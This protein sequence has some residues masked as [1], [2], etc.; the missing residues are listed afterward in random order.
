MSDCEHLIENALNCITNAENS[1]KNS[2][3]AF[4]EVMTYPHNAE[5]LRNVN[6][7]KDELWEMAYYVYLMMTDSNYGG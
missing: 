4:C 1:G 3:E 7:T 5:M 2:F 6:I